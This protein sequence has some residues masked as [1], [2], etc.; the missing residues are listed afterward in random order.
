MHVKKTDLVRTYMP[1]K[2]MKKKKSKKK[3]LAE[4]LKTSKEK[5]PQNCPL[6]FFRELEPDI[7]TH[8]DQ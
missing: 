3:M 8:I 6:I 7:V 1:A 4:S 2:K 5:F